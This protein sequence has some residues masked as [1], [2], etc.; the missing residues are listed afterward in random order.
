[1]R[2][3]QTSVEK[4]VKYSPVFITLLCP[5]VHSFLSY[6]SWNLHPQHDCIFSHLIE[7][8]SKFVWLTMWQLNTSKYFSNYQLSVRL[9]SAIDLRLT[10][11]PVV[12]SAGHEFLWVLCCVALASIARY[13]TFASAGP[14]RTAAPLSRENI[15]NPIFPALREVLSSLFLCAGGRSVAYY[16]AGGS[17]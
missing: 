8:T 5:V 1:M 10:P 17:F 7:E 14:M 12:K 9:H 6:A 13:D 11:A 3:S 2:Y 15:F 4:P 16:M